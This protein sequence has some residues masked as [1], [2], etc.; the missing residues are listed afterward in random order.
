MAGMSRGSNAGAV[1]DNFYTVADTNPNLYGEPLPADSLRIK[2]LK[3]TH[4]RRYAEAEILAHQWLR[5]E[6]ID[7]NVWN[8][9]AV[10]VWKQGRL[11]E[12]ERLFQYALR[13]DATN[14][15]LWTNLGHVLSEMERT[16][17]ALEAYQAAIDRK[18]DCFDAI[19]GAGVAISNDWK[20]EQAAPLLAAAVQLRP[21]SPE[22]LQNVGMNLGRMG[23]WHDAIVL[24]EEALRLKP[25]LQETQRN[26]GFAY[27]MVGDY[28]RGWPK[29]EWRLT[30]S[31]SIAC[32]INRTFW[33]GDDFRNQSILLHFE[34]GFGDIL[35]FVRY[36]PLVKRRGGRVVVLCPAPLMRL[37][38][39]CAG[40][41]QVYDGTGPEP[42]CHIHA[43]LMSLPAIFGTTLETI[44]AS[45]P[46]LH[47]EP[48]LVSHWRDVLNQELHATHAPDE[49][50][51]S[52]GITGTGRPFLIGIAWQGR[53]E[54]QTDN[55]RSFPLAQFEKIANIPDVR[56]VN[57]Q[58]GAG[59][60]QLV[61]LD[62]RFPIIDLPGRTGKDFT[63]TAA[64]MTLLDMVITPDTA[65]AHLAGG[66]AVRTWV[67][68]SRVGEWRWL[69]DREDSP[70]YPTMR[71]FRQSTLNVWDDVFERMAEAIGREL[72]DRGDSA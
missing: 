27:L 53:P 2:I 42:E 19:M 37:V 29:H 67:A 33:N 54:N 62:D 30:F 34:Q 22:A 55:I 1:I 14:Y 71:L 50:G 44:P 24:Y 13:I 35:Q 45:V 65:V 25:D 48:E 10:S 56:L 70:W 66:L 9:L 15:R 11:G 21:D 18:P 68:L 3:L 69:L 36:A 58:V 61:E 6:P 17:D 39:G 47:A 20:P 26:L 7:T 46:Y 72:A 12:A 63:E 40:V 32:R 28:A 4:E 23:R 49:A 8:E 60:E 59:L 5:F 57:L 38:S 43:P 52:A 41:D 31:N 16:D 64:I 51:G